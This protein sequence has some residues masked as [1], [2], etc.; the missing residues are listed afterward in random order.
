M[1][2][3][4]VHGALRADL[5][6]PHRIL[7]ADPDSAKLE[8]L[9]ALDV[10]VT[11]DSA[12]AANALDLTGLLL[13]AVKPQAFP[14][15]IQTTAPRLHPAAGVASIMAGVT[16]DKLRAAYPSVQAPPRPIIRA[17]PNLPVQVGQGMTALA[18]HSGVDAPQTALALRLFQSVGQTIHIPEPM[19]DAFTALAG[20][21]PAYLFYLAESLAKA[22]LPLGFSDKD[23]RAIVRQVLLGA[24]TL[25]SASD[26]PPETLRA[27]VTSKGGTTAAATAVLDAADVHATFAR[28]LKA[29]TDRGA[30]LGRA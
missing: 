15:V 12:S 27:G 9:A 26:T 28:A 3:A 24:A 14:T 11:T 19:M 20:S 7:V 8:P 18:I 25:L 17:M 10:A 23:A 22:A 13:L 1:G 29:A 30:E 21:G 5:L 2:A 4:L 6:P 16:C